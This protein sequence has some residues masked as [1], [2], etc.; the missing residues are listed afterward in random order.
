MER[1]SFIAPIEISF[2]FNRENFE[3]RLADSFCERLRFMALLHCNEDFLS[4][5]LHYESFKKT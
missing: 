1:R 4:N 5:V 3:V 2:R